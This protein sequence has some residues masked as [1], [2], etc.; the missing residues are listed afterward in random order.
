MKEK[1]KILHE[2]IKEEDIDI[3]IF[4]GAEIYMDIVILDLIKNN[5]I[6]TING[7]NKYVLIELPMGQIPMCSEKILFVL[8][9]GGLIPIIAHPERNH[10]I[11]KDIKRLKK[12]IDNGVLIQIN[13]GSLAGR[14][15][16]TIRKTAERLLIEGY[17]HSIASDSH[18]SYHPFIFYK[19]IK[20]AEKLI[21]REEVDN[22]V[23]KNP[24]K[25]LS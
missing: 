12:W 23:N 22:M 11:R 17:T 20:R 8:L 4:S 9:T 14:Y 24:E 13:G 7:S 5:K 10:E 21:G 16:T 15:G 19:G 6:I 2:R 25:I 1:I 18:S 3:E